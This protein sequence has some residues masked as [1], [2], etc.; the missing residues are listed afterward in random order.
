VHEGL[1][2]S[3]TY[4]SKS[5]VQGECEGKSAHVVANKKD[6]LTWSGPQGCPESDGHRQ[7]TVDQIKAAA[8]TVQASDILDV[9]KV[10]SF[11]GRAC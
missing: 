6:P 5:G 2:P 9:A 10:P 1:P 4:S 8:S 7:K 11:E 3:S